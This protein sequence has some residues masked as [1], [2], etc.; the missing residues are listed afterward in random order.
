[1]N[2]TALLIAAT[3]AAGTPLA[4]AGLALLL[5]DSR[6]RALLGGAGAIVLLWFAWKKTKPKYPSN[7]FPVETSPPEP[8]PTL[9]THSS[10]SPRLHGES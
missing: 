3:L 8:N 5:Q 4:L 2:E 7:A 6:L 9:S 1:M 10:V